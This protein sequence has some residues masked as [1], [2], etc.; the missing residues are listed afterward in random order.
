MQKIS[1]NVQEPYYPFIISGQKT[2]EGR[3]NKGKFASIQ[4]G[5]TLILAPK[6]IE[7]EVVGKNIY[8]SF[9][10][11]IKSE[12]VKN[13]VPDK[14]DIEE[15]VN[16]YYKFYTKE[17]E[18]EFGVSAIKIKKIKYIEKNKK[19]LSCRVSEKKRTDNE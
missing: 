1:I 19:I 5:D 8:N 9:K 4:E 16:V 7:F 15:A 12:G 10:E 3:L 11:M 17:Q 2:I 18:N 13:V 14:I 6:N